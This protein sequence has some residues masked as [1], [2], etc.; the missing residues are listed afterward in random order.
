MSDDIHKITLQMRA[1]RGNDP[2]KV[3]VGYYVI[4]PDNAVVITDENGKPLGGE[5][6]YLDSDGDAKLIAC[7]MLR[8]SERIERELCWSNKISKNRLLSFCGL[9]HMPAGMAGERSRQLLRSPPLS[10]IRFAAM[11]PPCCRKNGGVARTCRSWPPARKGPRLGHDP[12]SRRNPARLC[13]LAE[14][15]NRDSDRRR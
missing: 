5:K 9:A 3:A 8:E 7:R 10:Q 4:D 2:G 1:P 13:T 11:S 14:C 12:R 6:H 15:P